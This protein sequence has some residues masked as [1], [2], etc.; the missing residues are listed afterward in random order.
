VADFTLEM[1]SGV[2]LRRIRSFL[3]GREF[4]WPDVPSSIELR[5]H[6]NWSFFA[7]IGLAALAAWGIEMEKR[8]CSVVVTGNLDKLRYAARFGLFD[9][10]PTQTRIEV[11]EHEPAGRFVKLTRI[12]CAADMNKFVTDC[13]PLFHDDDV[14]RAST[15]CLGE[16]LRNVVEHSGGA[17]GVACAQY[18]PGLNRVSIAV[19]DCGIGLR[20][21]LERNYPEVRTDLDA[22]I[23]AVE[24]GSTGA[25]PYLYGGTE[26]AGL[27][28]YVSKQ[29]AKLSG[30]SFAL[31]S[32]ANGYH[33]RP[34][35]NEYYQELLWE[36]L[37]LDP[38]SETL[39]GLTWQGTLVALDIQVG[40]DYDFDLVMDSIHSATTIPGE[41]E[42]DIRFE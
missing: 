36:D 14:M 24:P 15:H 41:T 40:G 35:R 2:D 22:V 8:G 7:P 1:P 5:F 11:S 27:G 30:G 9:M 3:A 18:Y 12:E 6:T 23:K 28:L 39:D 38:V 33:V 20:T 37:L 21:S 25:A 34:S 17:T 19:A 4:P 29:I 16:L 31:A 10:I 42:V 13:A 26:N 32:G